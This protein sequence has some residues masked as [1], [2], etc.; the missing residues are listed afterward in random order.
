MKLG[1]LNVPFFSSIVYLTKPSHT[2]CKHI[3]SEG[4]NRVEG[5]PQSFLIRTKKPDALCV[6]QSGL[7]A[8]SIQYTHTHSHL[9]DTAA[10]DTNRI[11]NDMPD[12]HHILTSAAHLCRWWTCGGLRDD[13]HM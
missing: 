4:E 6:H 13:T 9:L 1:T 7:S 2:N 3:D 10:P 5:A 12:T 8:P 11:L